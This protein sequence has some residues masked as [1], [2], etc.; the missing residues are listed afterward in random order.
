MFNMSSFWNS[1][2]NSEAISTKP[3]TNVFTAAGVVPGTTTETTA[4]RSHT[5]I[6]APKT[7]SAKPAEKPKSP[8]LAKAPRVPHYRKEMKEAVKRVF[9]KLKRSRKPTPAKVVPEAPKAPQRP[10]QQNW[11]RRMP[12]AFAS[13]VLPSAVSLAASELKFRKF[14]PCLCFAC[15]QEMALEVGFDLDAAT[16]Y[17][18]MPGGADYVWFE[19]KCTRYPPRT[20]S[21]SPASYMSN[22][23][24]RFATRKI[25]PSNADDRFLD[26]GWEM[27]GNH[28]LLSFEAEPLVSFEAEPLVSVE[29]EPLVSAETEPLVSAEADAPVEDSAEPPFVLPDVHEFRARHGPQFEADLDEC[30]RFMDEQLVAYGFILPS[31]NSTNSIAN[32]PVALFAQ[33][34]HYWNMLLMVLIQTLNADTFVP[35]AAASTLDFPWCCA[36]APRFWGRIVYLPTIAKSVLAA[37]KAAPLSLVSRMDLR[38]PQLEF[39]DFL[40]DSEILGTNIA[41][42]DVLEHTVELLSS[43]EEFELDSDFSASDE[44]QRHTKLA[45]VSTGGENAPTAPRQPC[46]DSPNSSESEFA[47]DFEPDSLVLPRTRVLVSK[48]WLKQAPVAKRTVASQLTH[49]AVPLLWRKEYSHVDA[50]SL[51]APK[52]DA[53]RYVRK[54]QQLCD[55]QVSETAGS[56]KAAGAVHGA[57]LPDENLVACKSAAA[58][59]S[60]PTKFHREITLDFSDI[61]FDSTDCSTSAGLLVE[62]VEEP[63]EAPVEEPVAEEVFP[64]PW[65]DWASYEEAAIGVEAPPVREVEPPLEHGQLHPNKVGEIDD[66][67]PIALDAL[68]RFPKLAK[69]RLVPK[70]LPDWEQRSRHINVR[71]NNNFN[72]YNLNAPRDM[73][74]TKEV[75]CYSQREPASVLLR[76]EP[77]NHDEPGR[78]IIKRDNL[79]QDPP[80]REPRVDPIFNDDEFALM[81]A[82]VNAAISSRSLDACVEQF[83]KLFDYVAE[84]VL[85]EVYEPYFK[86]MHECADLAKELSVCHCLGIA[87]CLDLEAKFIDFA[88][89]DEFDDTTR[90]IMHLECALNEPT[91]AVRG[92]HKN[93]PRILNIIDENYRKAVEVNRMV[94]KLYLRF[95]EK[96]LPRNRLNYDIVERRSLKATFDAKVASLSRARPQVEDDMRWRWDML[97]S[98][99]ECTNSFAIDIDN[100]F[101]MTMIKERAFY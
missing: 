45:P 91:K 42:H 19:P 77:N 3:P 68:S 64:A 43:A 4:R 1:G 66:L 40:E 54:A 101:N 58:K 98:A 99:S 35:P 17:P 16:H 26:Y 2:L 75:L 29:T 79:K 27:A 28:P 71:F 94:Y 47:N 78:C 69:L 90:S 52:D 97:E 56:Q 41:K 44:E 13:L 39:L 72:P 100:L 51:L 36:V 62:P 49:N 31:T 96:V 12:A 81:L 34:S 10:P 82:K 9:S 86:F 63:V 8:K 18:E 88:H 55:T 50:A 25:A 20:F 73:S 65:V 95:V 59:V 33:P 93:V 22:D 46:S 76:H 85:L 30:I 11:E 89:I 32:L 24:T 48:P 67:L 70:W 60:S 83:H 6:R 7:K 14:V 37:V 5:K 21:R 38:K 84:T 57:A 87:I 15:Q 23:E 80:T 53:G 92:F 61:E 74:Y